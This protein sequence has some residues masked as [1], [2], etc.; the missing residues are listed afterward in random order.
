MSPNTHDKRTNKNKST[1]K[2][3]GWPTLVMSCL[4][5]ITVVGVVL[6]Q[7]TP[8]HGKAITYKLG[9]TAF[10]FPN[11]LSVYV[12]ENKDQI[13]RITKDSVTAYQLNGEVIWEDTITVQQ[14]V[15][16]QKEPYI[17]VSDIRSRKVA[18]FSEKGKQGEVVT[19]FPIV[20][21]SVNTNGDVATIEQTKEGHRISA[22]QK[23][24]KK[25][26]GQRITYIETAGFPIAVE[27]APDQS[28]L[29]ASYVDIYSP[30]VTTKVVG[31][32]LSVENVESVDNIQ[33][34]HEFKDNIIYELEYV[35]AKT[36][37]AIGESGM[38]YFNQKGESV[39]TIPPKYLKYTPYVQGEGQYLPVL[40]SSV[41]GNDALYGKHMLTLFDTMG[42]VIGEQTFEAPV[43]AYRADAQGV[44]VGQGKNYTGFDTRGRTLFT[45]HTPQDIEGIYYIGRK[46]VAVTKNEVIVLEQV[47]EEK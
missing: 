42:E 35:D 28:M 36:W 31:I 18:V 20:Y 37:V 24:G 26:P 5:M 8:M 22:Y 2:K 9:D 3:I 38:Q 1:H 39:A 10:S 4:L 21:F 34:G 23:N 17:A 46:P 12:G 19:E 44:I 30:I 7:L 11:T 40:E 15:V 29:L 45:L 47:R 27:V 43:T 32:P 33:F 13:V 41:Q 16:K 25:I 6:I 14:P